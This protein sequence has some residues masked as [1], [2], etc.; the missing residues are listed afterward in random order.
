MESEE[1]DKDIF[2]QVSQHF[3]SFFVCYI[4]QLVA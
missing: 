2:T 1:D 3:T 4:D